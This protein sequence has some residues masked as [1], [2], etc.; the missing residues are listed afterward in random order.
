MHDLTETE[1]YRVSLR[2]LGVSLVTTSLT[3]AAVKK[4]VASCSFSYRFLKR[5]G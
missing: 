5:A 1:P 2:A 3:K 4:T